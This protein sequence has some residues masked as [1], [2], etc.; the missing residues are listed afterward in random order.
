MH[1]KTKTNEE[2]LI[3]MSLI[4]PDQANVF[5]ENKGNRYEQQ[6]YEGI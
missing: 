5:R 2:S 3:R 6:A 4:G 1:I